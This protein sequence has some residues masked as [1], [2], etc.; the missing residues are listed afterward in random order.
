MILLFSKTTSINLPIS[1]PDNSKI[2]LLSFDYFDYFMI[3][4][5]IVPI[6]ILMKVLAY[7]NPPE[8]T[9]KLQI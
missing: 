5:K 6:K 7:V 3:L 1:S 9:E 4:T 2:K 8:M